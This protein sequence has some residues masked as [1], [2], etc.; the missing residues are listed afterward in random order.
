MPKKK[1]VEKI[2]T[3][4][5]CSIKFFHNRV[6]CE[7]MWTDSVQSGWPQMTI[8]RKRIACWI[9]EITN[10][11]SENV[12]LTAFPRQKWLH[13]R[14]LISRFKFIAC[15]VYL[16]TYFEIVFNY[17]I[18]LHVTN[19][20]INSVNFNITRFSTQTRKFSYRRYTL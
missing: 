6:I 12:L 14:A 3:Y 8:W 13:E 2:K 18:H 17:L 11:H 5:L 16:A 4:I 20:Y 10:T 19:Y 1:I 9:T 7:K 15:L